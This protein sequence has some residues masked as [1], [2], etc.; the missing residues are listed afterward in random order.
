M[1]V[2]INSPILCFALISARHYAHMLYMVYSIDS[3]NMLI[4]NVLDLVIVKQYY[5]TSIIFKRTRHSMSPHVLLMEALSLWNR[6]II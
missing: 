1:L 5:T 2:L 4:Q 3:P 6:A